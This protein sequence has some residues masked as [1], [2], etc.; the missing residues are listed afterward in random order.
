MITEEEP[1][2]VRPA[3]KVERELEKLFAFDGLK[4]DI[5]AMLTSSGIDEK[6]TNEIIAIIGKEETEKNRIAE[7]IR[8]AVAVY[9]GQAT[10]GKIIN[11]ILHEGRHPLNYF[12]NQI[13]NLNYWH[14]SYLE[15]GDSEK[16]DQLVVDR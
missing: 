4:R 1:D 12:R 14:K 16:L 8:Q 9:Q 5:R 7:D 13:P 3:L 11:V 2:S 15:T 10:L 6:T